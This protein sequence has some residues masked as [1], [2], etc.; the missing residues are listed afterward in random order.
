MRED[1]AFLNVQILRLRLVEDE[2]LMLNECKISF[3]SLEKN[4]R[5]YEVF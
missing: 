5:G 4:L 1:F 2:K 3:K